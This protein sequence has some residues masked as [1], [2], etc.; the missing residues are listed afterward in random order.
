MNNAINAYQLEN[1]KNQLQQ[2]LHTLLTEKFI[3]DPYNKAYLR[4]F[5]YQ[6]VQ[7]FEHK[8]YNALKLVEE[9][10]KNR[11]KLHKKLQKIKQ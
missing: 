9:Q 6:K 4:D 2:E 7:E 1:L 5:I 3:H 11:Y 10:H 8:N